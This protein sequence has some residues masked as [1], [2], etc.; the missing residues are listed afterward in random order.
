[1]GGANDYDNAPIWNTSVAEQNHDLVNTFWILAQIVPKHV[2]IFKMCLRIS[3]LGV[4]EMRE[5]S[6]ITDKEDWGVIEYPIE[7]TLL[8]FDLDSKSTGIT[9]GI[10]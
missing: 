3:F 10:G 2:W 8:S 6:G 5:F 4:N 7:I 9:S 1:M